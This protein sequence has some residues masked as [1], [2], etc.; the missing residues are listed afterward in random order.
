MNLHRLT[1]KICSAGTSLVLAAGAFAGSTLTMSSQAAAQPQLFMQLI[2]GGADLG[3][4]FQLVPPEGESLN[5]YSLS[6]DGTSQTPDSNG[7]CTV[8][9][10]YAQYMDDPF[11]L[12][13]MKNGTQVG[14]GKTISVDQYLETLLDNDAN[15]KFF[16]LAKSMLR[17]SEAA[18]AYWNGGNL[19]DC[20]DVTVSG[21]AFSAADKKELNTKLNSM[22]A[23]VRYAG[24]NLT[25]NGKL[26]FN[27]FFKPTDGTT[28]NKALEYLETASFGSDGTASLN[29]DQ[30]FV[31]LSTYV[32]ASEMAADYA[33]SL[34]AISMNFSP[35][36]Y[37]AAAAADSDEKLVTICKAL[38]AY[39]SEAKK[40]TGESPESDPLAGDEDE[41]EEEVREAHLTGYDHSVGCA[42]L[43]DYADEKQCAVVALTDE[44][45]ETYA[46]GWIEVTYGTK[47]MKALVADIMPLDDP[48]QQE[49]GVVAGDVDMDFPHFKEL[50]GASTGKF[51]ITWKP[52]ANPY[53]SAD[54]L[55]LKLKEGAKIY[56]ADIQI[57]NFKYP[58]ESI[59]LNGTT[60]NR[61]RN[62]SN[63]FINYYIANNIGTG[64]NGIYTFTV[65]D[66]YGTSCTVKTTQVITL[67]ENPQES[68]TYVPC[69]VVE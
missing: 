12:V 57:Q 26:Q 54:D 67:T 55:T 66:I 28:V 58:I 65:T 10:Q 60:L 2:A 42:N 37:L 9:E 1:K 69:K 51:D 62:P 5:G 32:P 36:Q 34:G 30:N 46:G 27:L 35:S 33:L 64:D 25:L 39:G 13:I 41:P 7:K 3:I 44:D 22:S 18:E 59:Q 29:R 49:N 31:R 15:E 47:T 48:V 17:Y 11:T 6:V 4:V 43:D 16:P 40:L 38:Y 20:S 63:Q 56:W 45:Y 52:I 19:P 14:K 68:I 24:M 61:D 8:R 23:P 53:Y 21:T 50:T